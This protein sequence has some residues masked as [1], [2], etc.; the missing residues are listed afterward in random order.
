MTPIYNESAKMNTIGIDVSKDELVCS[1]SKSR[2]RISVSNDEQGYQVLAGAVGQLQSPQ[3]VVEA[4]GGY[5][6]DVVRYLRTQNIFTAVVNPRQVRDFAKSKGRLEKTDKI[7]AQM[8]ALFG[9]GQTLRNAPI[10]SVNERDREQLVSRRSQLV[11]SR[12]AET[13]RLLRAQTPSVEQSIKR[14]LEFIQNEIKEID[15]QL[16]KMVKECPKARRRYEILTSVPGVGPVTAHTMICD[17]PELGKLNRREAAKLIGLAPLNQDSGKFRG[18]RR[19]AK[20]RV[21]PR[22][23]LYMATLSAKTH[24]PTIKNHFEKL[25]ANGKPFK[26][27]MVACMRK[28]LTILNVMIK[29]NTPWQTAEPTK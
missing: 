15:E 7:D 8:I 19:I 27:A 11:K 21:A 14:S 28:L 22:N 5:E 29:N 23:I 4:T 9:Q 1:C 26:V 10:L 25:T 3:V 16:A 12:T 13:N 6:K 17:V 24:N 2:W 20:G 18:S